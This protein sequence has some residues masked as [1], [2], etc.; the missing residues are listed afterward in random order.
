MKKRKEFE[1]TVRRVGRWSLGV[2]AKVG[3]AWEVAAT[4]AGGLG[5]WCDPALMNDAVGRCGTPVVH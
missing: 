2:W 4:V 1:D 5:A 3:A